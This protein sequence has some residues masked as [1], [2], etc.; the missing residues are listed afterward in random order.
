MQLHPCIRR[1]S[2][3]TLAYA[4]ACM[5]CADR[6]PNVVNPRSFPVHAGARTRPWSY[7]P[8]LN[9]RILVAVHRPYI[10]HLTFGINQIIVLPLVQHICGSPTMHKAVDHHL[11]GRARPCPRPEEIIRLIENTCGSSQH[12][13]DFG[14]FSTSLYDTAW[15]SMVPSGRDQNTRL[16]PQCLDVLLLA[17][18]PDGTWPSYAS[19]TDGILVS[20]AALLSLATNRAQTCS[21]SDERDRFAEPIER[22]VT[23]VEKLLQSWEVEDAVHVGFE[24]LI[25]SLIRQLE[26]RAINFNFPKLDKLMEFYKQKIRNF[27]PELLYGQKETTL[28]H[29]VEAFVGLIDFERIS[30]RCSEELGVLG[31]P[32]ATAAYLIHSTEWDSSAEMYLQ[33]VFIANGSTGKVPSAFPTSLFEVPWVSISGLPIQCYEN[34]R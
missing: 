4:A 3:L 11:P 28:L 2:F 20:L 16:F 30:H 26:S 19:P 10:Y 1:P 21:P 34:T 33:R 8:I 22:G 15:L 12:L 6:Y 5:G 32:A 29:S 25:T 13:N 17:Q 24:I 14:S 23:G 31:S 18:L 9:M 7:M 27:S